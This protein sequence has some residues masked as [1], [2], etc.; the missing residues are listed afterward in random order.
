MAQRWRSENDFPES[1]S[2]YSTDLGNQPHIF[3][4]GGNIYPFSNPVQTL[5]L[6][7]SSTLVCVC[8]CIKKSWLMLRTV[9]NDSS[10]LLLRN[11][12]SIKPQSGPLDSLCLYPVCSGIFLVFAIR[13]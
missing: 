4:T 3:R 5:E 6:A 2:L 12:F 11:G 8:A 1:F 10:S 7:F 13:D 9:L